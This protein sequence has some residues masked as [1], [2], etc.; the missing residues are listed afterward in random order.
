M[1]K[2]EFKQTV[3]GI[4]RYIFKKTYVPIQKPNKDKFLDDLFHKIQDYSY[5]P[6]NPR[7]YIVFN[8]H[9]LVSR[10]VPILAVADICVYYFCIKSLE[11][12]LANNRVDGT[13]GGFS[14]SGELR[15][16]ENTEFDSLNEIPLSISAHTYN[17]LAWVNAWRDFQK[18]AFTY[19]NQDD[20]SYFI[21]F[22]IA[23]FYDCINLRTCLIS[24]D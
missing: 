21:K 22:D 5:T 17:P 3:S 15:N 9:N 13:Y 24:F 6:S 1:K 14:M 20:Y 11:K 7:E 16:K 12:E 8:K 23:N 4:W 2:V 19:S 10:I 18:K